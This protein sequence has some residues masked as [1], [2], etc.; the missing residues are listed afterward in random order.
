MKH[1]SAA[2]QDTYGR[3]GLLPLPERAH[4]PPG[5][6]YGATNLFGSA[7]SADATTRAPWIS[8]DPAMPDQLPRTP[9]AAQ[10]DAAGHAADA[11]Y[12]RRPMDEFAPADTG[13]AYHTNPD[14]RSGAAY[15]SA[16]SAAVDD[17]EPAGEVTEPVA[18]RPAI[19]RPADL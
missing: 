17:A 4:E 15:R 9:F 6:A 14:A 13:E 12:P 2:G 19:F 16:D 11:R 1:A 3:T 5:G 8:G 10:P 18:T 7:P